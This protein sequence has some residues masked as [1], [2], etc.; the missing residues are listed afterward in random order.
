MKFSWHGKVV[1]ARK[2][3]AWKFLENQFYIST[4]STL[5]APPRKSISHIKQLGIS[6]KS[7]SSLHQMHRHSTCAVNKHGHFNCLYTIC[8]VVAPNHELGSR[9]ERWKMR[10]DGFLHHSP[11]SPFNTRSS[12]ALIFKA[13]KSFTDTQWD[14]WVELQESPGTS[15]GCW[16]WIH[17]LFWKVSLPDLT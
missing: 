9:H 12:L 10:P 17:H 14:H 13:R 3:Y 5:Y 15:C 11:A 16:K 1:W 4:S 7:E 6:W 2:R 8:G